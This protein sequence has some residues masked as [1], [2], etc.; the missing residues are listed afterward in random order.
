MK[1]GGIGGANTRTGLEFEKRSSLADVFSKSKK[2]TV[3]G[4]DVLYKN[5]KVAEIFVKN[6]LYSKLLKPKKVNVK[7]LISKRLMPDSALLVKKTLYIIEMKFQKV[8]GSVDEKLQTCDFKNKQYKKLLSPLGIKVK[9][10]Y[11]LN[12][13]FAKKEYKDTLKYVK[14]VSCYYFFN[15]LPFKFL[16]LPKH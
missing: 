13:W 7:K 11:L 16:N 8:A 4:R 15:K 2:Y 3:S 6:E 1:E 10:V 14:S 9:Y 12:D 5:K